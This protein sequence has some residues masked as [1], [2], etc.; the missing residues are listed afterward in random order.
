MRLLAYIFL[1]RVQHTDSEKLPG[2]NHKKVPIARNIIPAR[3]NIIL[4]YQSNFSFVRAEM[5][6]I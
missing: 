6:Q 3:P 4:P 5:L 1:N 2:I